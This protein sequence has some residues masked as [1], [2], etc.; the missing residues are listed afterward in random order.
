MSRSDTVPYDASLTEY[1][2]QAESLFTALQAGDEVAQWRFKWMHPRFK[3][4]HV[5]EVKAATLSL[6]DAK[7][8]IAREC[9]FDNWDTLAAYTEVV[10]TDGPVRRFEQA[11]EAVVSGD[12]VTLRCLLQADPKLVPAH[13]T[14]LHHA[15]L[16][17]Y[18]AA[19]GVENVRQKTPPQA[20]EIAKMLLEAGAVPDALADMYDSKCTTM[21]LLLSSAHPHEA[22]LQIALAETLLDHGAL[23]NGPGTNWTSSVLTSLTFGYPKTAE[24]LVRRGA[25]IENLV[26]AAGLGRV[27]EAARFLPT[28]DS[29]ARH[30]ALALAAHM[31]QTSTLK[32]LLDAGEDPDRLNPDGFHSHSTPL[33]QAVWADHLDMVKMLV[34]RGV[35][36]D[37]RDTIYDGTPLDWAKHGK[38]TAI[39]DYLQG[40]A[41]R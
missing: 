26:V 14:R 11:V 29:L 16:L 5:N 21:S 19:N 7:L 13:S 12:V 28:S 34:E 36:L 25:P 8:L 24:A 23:V 40:V 15:T 30:Q 27:E 6:E 1:Q 3:G 41:K 33:H 18:V 2:H 20:V 31:G 37:V 17:H 35:R 9:F 39:A 22:G 4:K 32:L 10:K 38:R